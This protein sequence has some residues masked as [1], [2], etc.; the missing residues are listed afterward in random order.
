MAGDQWGAASAGDGLTLYDFMAMLCKTVMERDKKEQEEWYELAR[1]DLNG[2]VQKAKGCIPWLENSG[3]LYSDLDGMR[4]WNRTDFDSLEEEERRA[5]L[6][7]ILARLDIILSLEK[8]LPL[9]LTGRECP[10]IGE[11]D[12]GSSDS[13]Y[14]FEALNPLTKDKYG[15]LLPRLKCEWQRED[16]NIEYLEKNPLAVVLNNYFW[17]PQNESYHMTH[18]YCDIRGTGPNMGLIAKQPPFKIITSPLGRS[19]PFV[20]ELDKEAKKFYLWYTDGC[21]GRLITQM[22]KIL[23]YAGKKKADIALFPEMMGTEAVLKACEERIAGTFGHVPKITFLPTFEHKEGGK[24]YNTLRILD[25]NGECIYQYNKMYAFCFDKKEKEEYGNL[26]KA[27][28]LEPIEGGREACVIHVPG[29]G[30]IGVLI[31]ADVF[32]KNYLPMLL[33]DMKITLLLLPVFSYGK[34]MMERA[35][36]PALKYA[37]DVVLCNTC[38]AWDGMLDELEDRKENRGY[39]PDFINIYYPL[40]HKQMKKPPFYGLGCVDCHKT[41]CHGCVFIA[42]PAK[43]HKG[44]STM[45]KQIR[46]E[47]I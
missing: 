46:L 43:T 16:R 45:S 11:G 26:E 32:K 40:G 33:E 18:L 28:Y 19:A 36:S 23:D 31:C 29:I 6:L 41:A 34:E 20:A 42:Q 21:D 9:F 5:V 1:D 2:C 22:E 35:L 25:K 47:A 39:L 7:G 38:A 10:V 13:F 12:A 8:N 15:I 17:V 24:W 3:V 27:H 14:S 44:R 4:L 37:C 30:R